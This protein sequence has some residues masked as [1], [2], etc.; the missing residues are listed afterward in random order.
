MTLVFPAGKCG[1]T[2]VDRN[3]FKLMVER[4]GEAFTSLGAGQIGPAS[5]FMDQFE[6]KKKDFSMKNPSKRLHRL[7]L[8]MPS[9]QL[10]PEIQK[11]YEKRS[12]SVLLRPEDFKS[13]FDPVIDKIEQLVQDQVSEVERRE[14]SSISTIILVGG[15]GS[16]PYL[17]ERLESWCK[18]R[19]IRLKLP[20]TDGYAHLTP[21]EF[22]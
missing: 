16:S 7:I 12:S 18:Q 9:L 6:L 22:V 19:K 20:W 11:Y 3:F 2:F 21:S 1:G 8:P 15:F 10:T 5:S 13:L 17:N 4:F 14:G